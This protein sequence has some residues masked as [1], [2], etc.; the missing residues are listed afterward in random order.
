MKNIIRTLMALFLALAMPCA[1]GLAQTARGTIQ[2]RVTDTS[3]AVLQGAT[4]TVAPGGAHPVTAAAGSYVIA[5][6]APGTY[7][8]TVSFVGFKETTR[9]ATVAAGQPVRVDATLDVAGQSEAI[10][11]TAERPRGEAG[12][13]NRERTA[14]N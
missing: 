7:T 14:D 8:I 12:Q 5:G 13:I 1:N 6:L 11:V 9:E 2:G 4:V 10:L 3:N